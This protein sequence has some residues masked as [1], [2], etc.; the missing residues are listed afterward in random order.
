[1]LAKTT[2][3]RWAAGTAALIFAAGLL[4]PDQPVIPVQGATARDW[5]HQSF[6]FEPWGASGVHKG[7]DVFAP[8]GR[9]AV[10]AVPGLVVYA[11][12]LGLGGNV[13]AILGP[14]W[15]VHYYAH[16]E[17]RHVGVLS[18]VGRAQAVGTVGSTGNAAGKAPHLHYS[19]LSLLPLPWRF[20]TATQ[21]WK[22]MFFLDPD[23]LLRQR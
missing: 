4:I 3:R 5:N 16:L 9:P 7:I 13:V 14:R 19:V 10:A 21:G 6:W 12:T 11:G 20:S 18:W 17:D 22:Q 1:M 2:L 8:R 15:R 23:E